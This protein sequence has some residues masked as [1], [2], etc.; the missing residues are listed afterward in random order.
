ME[1]TRRTGRV[2]EN[3]WKCDYCGRKN[4]GRDRECAGCGRPKG[5]NIE[6]DHNHIAALE[7]AEAEKYKKPEWF[8][9]C[10]DSFNPD[11][12]TECKSCGAPRGA[13]KD[14]FEIKRER[15][16]AAASEEPVLSHDESK[17][18]DEPG[19]FHPSFETPPTEMIPHQ[20]K[21][22]TRIPGI[23]KKLLTIIC[24]GLI[25]I[26]IILFMIWLLKPE[27]KTGTVTE[28][29][30]T[31][32]I[33]LEEL[34]TYKDEGW[35][36][37]IEAR[38]TDSYQKFKETKQVVDHY[39]TVQV[40]VTK[41]KTVKDPDLVWY[42]YEDLGN[43]FDEEIEHRLEQSHE[44]PYTVYEDTQ[45][46][47]YVDVDVYAEWY[48]YEYDKWVIKDTKTTQGNKGEEHDPVLTASGD[49]QRLTGYSRSFYVYVSSEDE[50]MNF[51][52]PKEMY[53]HLEVG[54]VVTFEI[55]RLGI[56]GII[57]INGDPVE[58]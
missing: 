31:S 9:E 50:D 27:E 23:L 16:R 17:H 35:D 15:E 28:F 44:E 41:Y 45:V 33:S 26:P 2:L 12:L 22:N 46:P 29:T 24:A 11:E 3:T 42:T 55:N 39:D 13:S 20:N 36:P 30:W 18:Q 53:D 57:R 19:A 56:G 40:P 6:Y 37:P 54:D 5:K 58:E 25:I 51:T 47:V 32:S 49:R 8:C 14:Y 48:E 1:T 43:G 4:R 21:H 34:V 38:V 10:C 7:G 52:V